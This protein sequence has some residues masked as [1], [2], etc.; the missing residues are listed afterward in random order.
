MIYTMKPESENF[1]RK[2]IQDRFEK[3]FNR[4]MTAKERACFFLP[5]EEEDENASD[6]GGPGETNHD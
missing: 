1:T 5:P 2:E 6:A 3:L 4:P